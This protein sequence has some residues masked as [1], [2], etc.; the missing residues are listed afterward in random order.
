MH[1]VHPLSRLL[2][3]D[4]VRPSIAVSHYAAAT[5]LGVFQSLNL[6]LESGLVKFCAIFRARDFPSCSPTPVTFHVHASRQAV[7]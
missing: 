1:H 7:I 5:A 4:V 2:E 3:T 6:A